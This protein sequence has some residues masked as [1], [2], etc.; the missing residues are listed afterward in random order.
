MKMRAWTSLTFPVVKRSL[1]SCVLI[2][3]RNRYYWEARPEN[4]HRK[5]LMQITLP[6]LSR[7]PVFDPDRMQPE[8]EEEKLFG[9]DAVLLNEVKNILPENKMIAV[10]LR[11]QMETI[12][13]YRMRHELKKEGIYVEEYPTHV[14]EFALR[15]TKWD[16]LMSLYDNQTLTLYSKE[17]KVEEMLKIAR[18][19]PHISLMGGIINDRLMSAIQMSQ[20]A[21]L[22]TLPECHS[23][24]SFTIATQC[25]STR[26]ILQRHQTLLVQYLEQHCQKKD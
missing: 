23:Q 5:L 24:L 10:Y 8:V 18:K 22:P 12:D 7:S 9:L 11:A 1:G 3:K 6:R 26:N 21:K 19:N 25:A 2:P 4:K 15:D 14:M 20:F 16:N 17:A 13:F